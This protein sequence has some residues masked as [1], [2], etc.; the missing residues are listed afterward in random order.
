[1]GRTVRALGADGSR[2]FEVYLKSE[3]FGKV[4]REKITSGRRGST[5]DSLKLTS[6][7]TE[8]CAAREVQADGPRGP[9]GRPAW[10]NGQL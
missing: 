2:A 6:N 10:C 4:F 5:A 7:H 1:V 3:V 8:R 9:G